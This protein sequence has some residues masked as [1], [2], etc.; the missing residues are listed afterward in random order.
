MLGKLQTRTNIDSCRCCFGLVVLVVL[1]ARKGKYSQ[2]SRSRRSGG[3]KNCELKGKGRTSRI[4]SKVAEK[5][6]R[7]VGDG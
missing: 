3:G 7:E 6:T 2:W 5:L 1:V 4:R